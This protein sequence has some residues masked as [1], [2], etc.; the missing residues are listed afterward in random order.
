MS[1]FPSTGRIGEVLL[2]SEDLENK[3]FDL[4]VDAPVFD[5]IAYLMKHNRLPGVSHYG[6][7]ENCEYSTTVNNCKNIYL[8]SNLTGCENI[9]Y[10][11][12]VKYSNDVHNSVMVWDNASCVFNSFAVFRSHE[13]FYSTNIS[14]SHQ[15][16]FSSNLIGCKECINCEGLENVSYHIDN[17][18][19]EQE[20]YERLKKER[21]EDKKSFTR[22][23]QSTMFGYTPYTEDVEN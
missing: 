16:L 14:N 4:N 10:S 21:L 18:A 7:S 23:I 20:D 19:Y 1:N 17:Q 3:E 8:A 22:K 12:S 15:I 9:F 2:S 11:Y 6:D 13:V 5:N